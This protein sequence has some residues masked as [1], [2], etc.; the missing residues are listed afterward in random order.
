MNIDFIS[1]NL[2]KYDEEISLSFT[3][4]EISI[5]HYEWKFIEWYN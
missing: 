3:I 5:L 1:K 4:D 2:N